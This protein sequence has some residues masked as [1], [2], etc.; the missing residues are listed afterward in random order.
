MKRMSS[1]VPDAAPPQLPRARIDRTPIRGAQGVRFDAWSAVSPRAKSGLGWL[2]VVL[3]SGLCLLV[4]GYHVVHHRVLTTHQ[5]VHCE[6][7]R[8]MFQSGDWLIPTYGGRPWLERPPLPHW[9]TGIAAELVGS[10]DDE[11]A[12]RA[13]SIVAGIAAVLL[14]AQ[15]AAVF[16]GRAVGLLSGAILATMFEFVEYATGPEADIFLCTAVLLAN[17]LLVRIEFV[18][19]AGNVATVFTFLGKRSWTTAAFFMAL[20]LTNLIKGPFFGMLFIVLPLAGFYLWNADIKGLRRFVWL[21]G[22]LSFAVAG[23]AWYAAA[24]WR[25]PDMI[26]LWYLTFCARVDT[27]TFGEP[28]WYY[29]ANQPWSIFPWTLPALVGLAMTAGRAIG[30]RGSPERYLWCLAI[31]PL[32]FLSV[33]RGKHHHYLLHALPPLAVLAA[34]GAAG[35]WRWLGQQKAWLRQPWL[36][37]LVLGAAG[38]AALLAFQS[39]I[40]GSA[41]LRPALLA[42][43]PALVFLAWWAAGRHSGRVAAVGIFAVVVVGEC[44]VYAGRAEFLNSYEH[45]MEFLQQAVE[46]VPANQPLLVKNDAHPLNSSWFLFYLPGRGRLLHNLTFLRASD[47]PREEVYLIAR[48]ED[49]AS[50]SEYGTAEMVLRSVKTRGEK[51]PDDRWALFHLRFYADLARFPGNVRISPAQAAGLVVGPFL[52]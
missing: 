29:L 1:T 10:L 12:M 14:L 33:P 19:R 48:S 20:G 6:N 15:L 46:R 31:L 37:A 50:L 18:E 22:W 44:L 30:Q 16:Y 27:D 11:G 32:V 9:L 36:P 13:G 2:D 34:L 40:P 42:G 4:Y 23:G 41:W 38:D 39:R 25:Y 28:F 51:S 43:W 24:L 3:L 47:L 17:A 21:W 35:M 8:E 52:R 5:A 7:V 45:D 49:W 26:D